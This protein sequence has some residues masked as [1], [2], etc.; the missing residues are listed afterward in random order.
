MHNSFYAQTIDFT[1]QVK[2]V[3]VSEEQVILIV[4]DPYTAFTLQF[5]GINAGILY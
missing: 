4:G 2:S 1:N 5:D 3:G